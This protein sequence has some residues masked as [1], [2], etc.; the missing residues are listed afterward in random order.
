AAIASCVASTIGMEAARAGLELISLEVEVDSE[1]DDRGIL[2]MD[3][4]IPP[5]PISARIRIHATANQMDGHALR[6]VIE[7]GAMRCPVLDAT[8]RAIEIDLEIE[9]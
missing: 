1:S 5:G 9:A 7:R 3:E 2:G 4:S 8:Q 6:H